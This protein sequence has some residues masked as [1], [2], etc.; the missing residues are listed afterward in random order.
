MQIFEKSSL[1]DCDIVKLFDFHLDVNN[2]QKIT[3]ANMHVSLLNPDFVPKQ[4]AR[5]KIKSTKY[6]LS[7]YW[8]VEIRTLQSPNLLVDVAIKS[9]FRSWEHRHIFTQIGNQCE[10]RDVVMFELPFGFLGSLLNPLVQKELNNMFEFRH[11]IT[12]Q[13]LKEAS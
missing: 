13:L 5:L 2:L 6:M 12:K 11:N 8:E 4:G 3:P 1:L 9:P 10:L 7:S